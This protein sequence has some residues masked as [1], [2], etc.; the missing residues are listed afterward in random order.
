[1]TFEYPS[2]GAE[3]KRTQAIVPTHSND[4]LESVPLEEIGAA[5]A[6]ALYNRYRTT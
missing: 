5:I 3:R 1:M 4:A 2:D 6:G